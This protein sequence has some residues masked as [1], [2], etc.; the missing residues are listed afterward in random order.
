N[1]NLT[2]HDQ[3]DEV[4][5]FIDFW[6]RLTGRDPQW[7][8]FDSKLTDYPQ[9]SQ[10]NQRGISFVTI[11]RRGQAMMRRLEKLPARAWQRTRLD[12]PKRLHKN[13]RYVDQTISLRGYQGSLRQIAVAGMGREQFT[14]FL[15]NN[16]QASPRDIILRYTRRNGIEDNLGISVNFFHLDCL[17]SEVR[18]NVDVDVALTVV[19]NGCYRWLARQLHGFDK[20]KAK[21]LYRRFVE[22]GGRIDIP[23]E[24]ILVHFDKRSHTPILR[25]AALDRHCPPIPW[26]GNRT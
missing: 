22:T 20:A 18:L 13:I 5:R 14:L 19:A 6:Q 12:I 8:Y 4:L 15:C 26:L 23:P 24:Q 1:A 25:E 7:L 2:R 17:A 11:R 9:L 3:A 21:D 16:D 10:I